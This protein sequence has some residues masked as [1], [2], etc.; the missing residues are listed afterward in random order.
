MEGTVIK[1]SLESPHGGQ[2][3]VWGV[4]GKKKVLLGLL[5]FC[6]FIPR[7][8]HSDASPM[9]LDVYFQ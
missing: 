9:N 8:F 4:F 2:R 6:L 1:V 3:D 5:F 7:E